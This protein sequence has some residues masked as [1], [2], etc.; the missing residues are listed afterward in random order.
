MN[1]AQD[2]IRR[3][4]DRVAE[5]YAERF[6]RELASKPLDRAI[7]DVFAEAMRGRGPVLDIGCGPG[8]VARYL[9]DR[10][11]AVEG[12]DLS[13]SRP[14]VTLSSSVDHPGLRPQAEDHGPTSRW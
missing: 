7:L 5:E 3:S 8:Q 14:I 10:G 1:E 9:F 13:Q 4:Y 6:L 12:V 11:A 2:A